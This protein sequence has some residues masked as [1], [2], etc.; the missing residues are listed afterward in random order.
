MRTDFITA[1]VWFRL[2]AFV[3]VAG[4]ALAANGRWQAETAPPGRPALPADV[5]PVLAGG[6]QMTAMEPPSA[7]GRQE[8]WASYQAGP[9]RQQ[10][11]VS[12]SYGVQ[13]FHSW[14]G[15]FLIEGPQ[16]LWSGTLKI[17]TPQGPARLEATVLQQTGEVRAVAH[18]EC[19][20]GRWRG[21]EWQN[22]W[23]ALWRRPGERVPLLNA[24]IVMDASQAAQHAQ[25]NAL[26]G[27]LQTFL[28][29]LNWQTLNAT[30]SSAR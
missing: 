28:S 8:R 20:R 22:R 14:I 3:L 1:R 6:F 26:R 10:A 7:L 23:F 15:C 9:A 2:L 5:F 16:P 17:A 29:S 25:V 27:Q 18:S 21:S 19:W 13:S 12:L 24:Y 4:L 11:Y 30:C